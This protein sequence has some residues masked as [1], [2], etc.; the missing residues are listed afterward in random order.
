MDTTRSFLSDPL[1]SDPQRLPAIR[2]YYER[3]LRLASVIARGAGVAFGERGGEVELAS[4]VVNL[5][6]AFE[7][8]L[9]FVLTS[10]LHDFLPV[11][12]VLD[13]NDTESDGG[14]KRLF[15]TV[16]QEDLDPK[17]DATP[18]IVLEI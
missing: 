12:Q 14:G 5:E 8:Y 16:S 11:V 9:R 10:G 2:A 3:A 18:D 7:A 6:D 17:S 4:L 15:D 1:V 13:G